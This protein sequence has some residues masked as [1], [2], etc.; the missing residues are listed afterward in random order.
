MKT[1]VRVGIGGEEG[2]RMAAATRRG[3]MVLV[4][5]WW[6]NSA[7]VLGGGVSVGFSQR[8]YGFV[9]EEGGARGG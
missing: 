8:S 3:P 6:E 9:E 5:R 7:K 2:L 4:M 1:R